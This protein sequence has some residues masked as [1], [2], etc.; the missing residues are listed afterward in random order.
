MESLVLHKF[1]FFFFKFS[2]EISVFAE[3]I[4]TNCEECI[5]KMEELST[6]LVRIIKENQMQSRSQPETN[7][8]MPPFESYKPLKNQFIAFK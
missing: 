5:V 1:C 4:E 8:F 7:R 3:M 6:K 2:M